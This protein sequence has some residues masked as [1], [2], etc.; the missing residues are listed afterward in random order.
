MP[1][2]QVLVQLDDELL[3]ALDRYT[4]GRRTRSA[5]IRRALAEWLERRMYEEA[6]RED[7]EAYTRYPEDPAGPWG[8]AGNA[9]LMREWANH[10]ADDPEPWLAAEDVP[11]SGS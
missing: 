7:V 1:R 5:L 9:Y 2:K 4:G 8:E 6:A 10:I 11:P 3:A